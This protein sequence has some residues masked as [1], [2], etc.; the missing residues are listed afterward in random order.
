MYSL[1]QIFLDDFGICMLSFEIQ[2]SVILVCWLFIKDSK[3]C[4]NKAAL[5]GALPSVAEDFMMR[6]Q[7]PSSGFSFHHHREICRLLVTFSQM[8]CFQD[9]VRKGARNQL[10]DSPRLAQG[11]GERK[12]LD[13]DA[14]CARQR[15]HASQGWPSCSTSAVFAGVRCQVAGRLAGYCAFGGKKTFAQIRSSRG[16]SSG[17]SSARHRTYET[18]I[19]TLDLLAFLFF[20]TL[21]FIFTPVYTH[22]TAILYGIPKN[23]YYIGYSA[24]LCPS[25]S[26]LVEHHCT[27]GHPFSI[28]TLANK[29]DKTVT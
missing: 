12:S 17:S 13:D 25:T 11:G 28:S 4:L 24:K 6:L 2:I 19:L 1:L 20:V 7:F 18:S 27:A 26:R 29:R 10:H 5:S 16:L 9:P 3:S 22:H 8:L 15:L 21:Y 23:A 14:A